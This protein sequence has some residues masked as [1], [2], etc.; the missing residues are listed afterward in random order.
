MATPTTAAVI[1]NGGTTS[2]SIALGNLELVGVDCP[3]ISAASISIAVSSDGGATFKTLVT[4]STGNGT[5]GAYTI[6]PASST[7]NVYVAVNTTYFLGVDYIQLVSS[8]SQGA[9]RTFNLH[10]RVKG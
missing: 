10:L 5:N 7:G 6:L 1:P 3:T 8:A 2:N 4:D 9:A